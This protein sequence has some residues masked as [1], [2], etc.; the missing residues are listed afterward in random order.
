MI[1]PSQPEAAAF[2]GMLA[3]SKVMEALD[4]IEH[5]ALVS[6]LV[7][8]VLGLTVR[9]SPTRRG[10]PSRHFSQYPAS[11]DTSSFCEKF[12]SEPVVLRRLGGSHCCPANRSRSVQA[13]RESVLAKRET[14]AYRPLT[15]Q[16]QCWLLS[17][18]ERKDR[19]GFVSRVPLYPTDDGGHRHS[20]ELRL[21]SLSHQNV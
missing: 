3:P 1:R 14:E 20:P 13:C 15:C 6:S 4:I 2:A 16:A 17:R 9:F 7:L 8:C 21:R 12:S 10:S 5:T 19:H 11:V 18:D